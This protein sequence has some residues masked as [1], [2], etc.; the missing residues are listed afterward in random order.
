M[1][2]GRVG[3]VFAFEAEERPPIDAQEPADQLRL[4]TLDER[5]ILYLR[6]VHGKRDFTSKEYSDARNLILDAMA[7]DIAAK[8][9]INLPEQPRVPTKPPEGLY[10]DGIVAAACAS[11]VDY[12]HNYEPDAAPSA[13]FFDDSVEYPAS[14]LVGPARHQ[15]ARRVRLSVARSAYELEAVL[16]RVFIPPPRA[17]VVPPPAAR[18]R[19]LAKR[20][21]H[22]CAASAIAGV[23]ALLLITILPTTTIR[24]VET[25]VVSS[26]LL[27]PQSATPLE[28]QAKETTLVQQ[29]GPEEMARLLQLGRGL[30]ALGNIS[31]ARLVLNRAA[32][33]GSAS[34]ALELGGTYDPIVLEE[35]GGRAVALNVPSPSPTKSATASASRQKDPPPISELGVRLQPAGVAA[36]RPSTPDMTIAPDVAMAR[37][38]YQKARDLGSTEAAGRLERLAARDGPAAPGRRPVSPPDQTPLPRPAPNR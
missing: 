25:P 14:E 18:V 32:E 4:P 17:A 38:W 20:S 9:E 22:I 30:I 13:R 34:A 24:R 16:P 1:I 2:R 10:P 29:L 27:P 21:V 35:L 28:T 36:D 37:A 12:R 33:A 23:V 11:S 7:A 5:V 15:S 31:S 6:A 26:A 3:R 8:S 19:K